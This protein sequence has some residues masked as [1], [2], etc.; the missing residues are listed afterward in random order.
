MAKDAGGPAPASREPAGV[1]A[2]SGVQVRV[3][4]PLAS[5]VEGFVYLFRQSGGLDPSAGANYVTYNFNLLSGNYKTTYKH[6]RRARTRRTRPSRIA[7]VLRTTS[8]TA[9]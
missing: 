6:H 8:A 1:V 3:T 7:E 9:G 4:D 5:D 2:N